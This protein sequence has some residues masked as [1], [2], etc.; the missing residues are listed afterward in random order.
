MR[1]GASRAAVV[2]AMTL[3]L[4][5]ACT[6]RNQDAASRPKQPVSV[7]AMARPASVSSGASGDA[8]A[9]VDAGQES[10]VAWTDPA[11]VRALLRGAT[12][13]DDVADPRACN[14][15]VPEQSCIP[16]AEAVEW[17]CKLGCAKDCGE[18]AT[19][20][21]TTLTTCRGPCKGDGACDQRCGQAAGAC[22]QGCLSSRDRC[23][24]GECVKTVAR[25]H[26]AWRTKFGC[27]G[28]GTPFQI[29]ERTHTCI[30]ACQDKRDPS[31]APSEA[32]ID[33]CKKK[34]AVGC[35]PHFVDNA[36][37]GACQTYDNSW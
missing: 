7:A 3:A 2:A 13:P 26:E 34:H 35:E 11:G 1:I 32:C 36:T 25:Y 16:N 9:V 18:C 21:A 24:T 5:S 8:S 10:F 31:K 15:Q 14:F 30:D 37:W 27:K 23:Y 6:E 19:T 22:V 4:S 12:V 17:D 28:S 29:C 33:A 20:C